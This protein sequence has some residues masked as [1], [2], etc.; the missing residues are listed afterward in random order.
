MKSVRFNHL[1]RLVM[2]AALTLGLAACGGGSKT[3]PTPEPEPTAL[4]VAQGNLTKAEAALNALSADASDADRLAA[5]TAVHMAA[6]AVVAQLKMDDASV[7]AVDAAQAK[8]TSAAAAMAATQT[9]IDGAALQATLMSAETTLAALGADATDADKLAAQDAVK[10]AAQAVVDHLVATGASYALVSAAQAKV[11]AADSAIATIQGRIDDAD[12]AAQARAKL[13]ADAK[14][15]LTTA[16]DAVDDDA[17]TAAQHQAVADA[18]GDLVTVLQ[19][20]GGSDSEVTMYMGVQTVA[21]TMADQATVES[22]EAALD[23]AVAAMVADA[24]DAT[25]EAAEAAAAT[26]ATALETVTHLP[27]ADAATSKKRL[28]ANNKIIATTKTNVADAKAKQ[29]AADKDAKDKQDAADMAAMAAKGKALKPALDFTRPATWSIATTLASTLTINPSD[30]LTSTNSTSPLP[31]TDIVLNAGDAADALGDWNGKHY[32]RTTGS[33]TSKVTNTAVAYTNPDAAKKKAFTKLVLP[34]GTDLG[35]DTSQDWGYDSDSRT[36]NLPQLAATTHVAGAKFPTAGQKTFPGDSVTG[37]VVVRGTYQGAPGN[38]RCTGTCVAT[39]GSGGKVALND[40]WLFVHDEGAMVSIKDSNY[41]A[42]GWWLRED[43]H[44]PTHV[45]GFTATVG[46]AP[47]ALSGLQTATTITG[48]ASYVGKAAGKFA[49]YNPL[50]KSGDGGNFTA[51]ANLT[52]KFGGAASATNTLGVTG[53]IDNF[54]ANGA[55]V[56][57]SVSLKRASYSET[58]AIANSPGTTNAAKTVWSIDGNAAAASGSW[59]GQMYDELAGTVAQ[60]GDGSNVPT[61]ITGTY[62]ST[63]GSTHSMIGAF[64]AEKTTP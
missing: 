31:D 63:Y 46:T 11:T 54:M 14:T 23:T 55:S 44:G 33:G 50:D 37:V 61:T 60:G 9:R 24:S 47:S 39:A 56:P 52:A 12:A 5:Q 34:S 57:W 3:T 45:M 42:F 4:E 15:D 43:V 10:M 22:A 20:N 64:G 1:A 51:D 48:S 18:A 26:L 36:L 27:A 41:L 2:A 35:D 7:S 40:G 58:G 30:A 53:T 16:Q 21:Q 17:P 28:A 13:I 25:V 32:S 49:I 19:A 6:Q 59:Q 62:S 8:V 38:Y 29:D